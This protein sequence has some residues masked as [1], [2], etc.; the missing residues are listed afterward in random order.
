MIVSAIII[1][2]AI[3]YLGYQIGHLKINV[4]TPNRGSFSVSSTT[5]TKMAEI[6][7]KED[8]IEEFLNE[9]N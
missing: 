4:R 1:A 3:T 5:G 2:L 8:A 6:I 7:K 9:Q